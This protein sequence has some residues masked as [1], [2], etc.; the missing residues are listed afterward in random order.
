MKL[1]VTTTQH[2]ATGNGLPA[3]GE[4]TAFT[5]V[6]MLVSVVLV[7]LMML[8]FTEIFQILAGTM[9]VQQ[10]LSENDQRAR[11][12]VTTLQADL[13]KRTFQKLIPIHPSEITLSNLPSHFT[14]RRGYFHYS[15]N[16]PYDGTDDLLQFTIGA[17][18]TNRVDDTTPYYGR[19]TEL[20]ITTGDGGVLSYP[21]QP[22]A[23]DAQL[24]S[25]GTAESTNAEVCY[26]L[27]GG[28]LYRRTML[29]REPLDLKS[30]QGTEDQPTYFNTSTNQNEHF[31]DT[32]VLTPL[33][34]TSGDLWSGDFWRDFDYS[35]FYNTIPSP[36]YVRFN[37]TSSLDNTNSFEARFSLGHP[38]LRFGHNHANGLP[39]EFIDG[40]QYIG[41]F[42]HE[43][44]SHEDFNYP[45]SA[46]TAGGSNPM[47]PTGSSLTLDSD[48]V[49]TQFRKGARRAEDLVL[50]NVV[51]F[52]I[53][54][55][56]D[57][58]FSGQGG[59]VDIGSAD[60]ADY[61]TSANLEYKNNNPTTAFSTNMY[62]TWHIALDIDNLDMDDNRNTNT[63]TTSF[64]IP[65]F[66]PV[67]GSVPPNARPLKAIQIVIRYEDIPSGQLRQVSLI[68]PLIN[69]SEE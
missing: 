44:T 16:D 46:S 7:L 68:H 65:P 29:I 51:S 28:N 42:T 67:D 66:R 50:S 27:R 20:K 53:K 31:F 43:E 60:A 9:S 56:D 1:S 11:M 39:R 6:E 17:N 58:A 35:A 55:F 52:D 41:R 12:L 38:H 24:I 25:N 64:D 10:G 15:E 21:N 49:V 54:I 37:S 8:M 3:Q 63:D 32:N 23:D 2:N 22:E 18:V 30:I 33:I 47:N 48:S 14:G 5:L 19:A 69:L 45:Q 61:Q 26:F 62:D 34:N 4:R 59:F 13:D 36:A 57:S 40:N